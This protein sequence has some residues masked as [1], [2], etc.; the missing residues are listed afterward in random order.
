[1]TSAG[2]WT[3][4]DSVSFPTCLL[5]FYQ[6]LIPI[7]RPPP[8]A[9]HYGIIWARC[10]PGSRSAE[11]YRTVR[12][13][14]LFSVLVPEHQCLQPWVRKSARKEPIVH[15]LPYALPFIPPMTRSGSKSQMQ[16]M[17]PRHIS[18]YLHQYHLEAQARV[19]FLE[20]FTIVHSEVLLRSRD[21]DSLIT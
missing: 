2:L 17:T 10:L 3:P 21:S 12:R 15:T 1:V 4:L 16:S 8:Y 9:P 20:R 14:N 11:E 6:P 7:R 13:S 19:A 18:D 5:E